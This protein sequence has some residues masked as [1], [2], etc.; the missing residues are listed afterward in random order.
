M[1]S[2]NEDLQHGYLHVYCDQPQIRCLAHVVLFSSDLELSADKIIDITA[3]DSN[4]NSISETLNNTGV[5]RI[6]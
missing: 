3:S 2:H 5:L 6:G 4:W 1:P